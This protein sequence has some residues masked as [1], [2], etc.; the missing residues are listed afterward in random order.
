MSGIWLQGAEFIQGNDGGTYINAPWRGVLHTTEG[1]TAAG[2]IAEFASK[3]S[4]PHLTIEW[5]SKRIIQHLSLDVGARALEHLPNT[6]ETN[7]ANCVQIEIVGNAAVTPNWPADQLE[8]IASVMRM[9]EALLPIPRRSELFFKPFPASFGLNNGVRLSDSDWLAFTGWCGHQ[10]VPRQ[11]HGDPGQIDIDYLCSPRLLGVGS[12]QTSPG[13]SVVARTP[14]TLD[15]VTARA[16]RP[17]AEGWNGGWEGRGLPVGDGL[18]PPALAAG[19]AAVARRFDV[20]DTFWVGTDGSLNT[21]WWTRAGGWSPTRLRI[22]D[23]SVPVSTTGGIAALG[24]QPGVLDVFFVGQ[25]GRLYTTWWTEQAGWSSTNALLGGPLQVD[26]TGGVAAVNRRRDILDVFFVRQDGRLYT[27][28]WTEQTGWAT[29]S[30]PI[31][32]TPVPVNP[33]S[34]SAA[35]ARAPGNLDVVY[36]GGDMALYAVSWSE[37]TG[38]LSPVQIGG[39]GVPSASLVAGPA[40]VSRRPDVIDVFWIGQD[41]HLHTTWWTQAG[42]WNGGSLQIGDAGVTLS[43]VAT[44]AALARQANILD[45]FVSDQNGVVRTTWWTAAGGWNPGFLRLDL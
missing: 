3:N 6:V 31:G 41:S 4:W 39:A 1:S 28:W 7:L 14:Y 34:G 30:I 25:D 44:P 24:R 23:H 32:G 36:V 12:S 11:T 38:W 29:V 2:A 27:T 20:I 21:S 8:F 5:P 15:A 33:V 37:T 19:V 45:V 43:T 13:P 42:G 22:G 10:H 35:V 40:V 16:D 26:P 18:A 9:V 17:W